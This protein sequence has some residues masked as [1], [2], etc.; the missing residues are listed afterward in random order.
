MI[1]QTYAGDLREH[2]ANF[3]GSIGFCDGTF[4]RVPLTGAATSAT[5]LAKALPLAV[6][7]RGVKWS[8]LDSVK[9]DGV[10]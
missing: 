8:A 4:G 6:I 2:L 9:R 7:R 3:I 5:G 1:E 10:S